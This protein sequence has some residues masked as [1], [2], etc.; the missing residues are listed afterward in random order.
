MRG[1]DYKKRTGWTYL[2]FCECMNERNMRTIVNGILLLL[3]MWAMPASAQREKLDTLAFG[4]RFSFHTNMIDWLMGTPNATVELDI[5][6]SPYNRWALLGGM[7]YNWNTHHTQNPRIVY[8]VFEISGEGRYYWHTR[9]FT[10]RDSFERD[11]TVSFMSNLVRRIRTQS[12]LKNKPRTYRSYYLGAYGEYDNY[13]I[14]MGNGIQGKGVGVGVSAGFT[15]Q[16]YQ[17]KHGSI[18]LEVGGRVGFRYTRYDK[19]S[20]E[21]ESVCYA[22]EGTER[23]HFVPYPII[24]DIHVSLIYRLASSKKKYMWNEVRAAKRE[25]KRKVEIYERGEKLAKQKEKKTAE[26]QR[27][28]HYADSIAAQ[29]LKKHFEDSIADVQKKLRADSAKADKRVADSLKRL[30]KEQAKLMKQKAKEAERMRK[31]SIEAAKDSIENLKNVLP[32]VETPLDTVAHIEEVSL[33]EP[34]EIPLP[35]ENTRDS[36]PVNPEDGDEPTVPEKKDE[37]ETVPE[38]KPEEP[39]APIEEEDTETPV[40]EVVPE[41][42]SVPEEKKEEETEE[43]KPEE[44]DEEGGQQA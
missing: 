30:E 34:V 31:D 7:K 2:M 43:Q 37:E 10:K 40:P 6:G 1:A 5:S 33:P 17:M 44:Q 18:E 32:T 13:T 24:Q 11:S 28:K 42:P 26:N 38:V 12:T 29:K 21:E 9:Q 36:I 16:L 23:K 15:Q 22:Y 41:E 20:Y 19:F 35:E 27:K 39:E 25:E 8:N 4:K 14:L 3:C